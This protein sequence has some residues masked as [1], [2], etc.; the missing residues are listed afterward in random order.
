MGSNQASKESWLQQNVGRN[1]GLGEDL[2][3]HVLEQVQIRKYDFRKR[4]SRFLNI[5]GDISNF[6]AQPEE[7][8]CE[9]KAL[10]K[11]KPFMS[12]GYEGKSFLFLI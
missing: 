3:D 9:A 10:T 5:S 7:P 2:L 8:M 6:P 12:D 4:F 11:G 1:R